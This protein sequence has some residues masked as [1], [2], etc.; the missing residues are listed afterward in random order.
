MREE[1]P[2][3]ET[4]RYNYNTY[5]IE[6]QHS[7]IDLD[8]LESQFLCDVKSDREGVIASTNNYEYILIGR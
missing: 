4:W 2:Y 6:L 5:I 1:N 8:A 3:D 7:G